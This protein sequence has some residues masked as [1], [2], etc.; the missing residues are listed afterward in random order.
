MGKKKK[1]II[2]AMSLW[3]V[4]DLGNGGRFSWLEEFERDNVPVNQNGILALSA[5]EHDKIS[6]KVKLG[7]GAEAS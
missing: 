6:H 3:R 5:K 4:G 1:K 7:I 2:L